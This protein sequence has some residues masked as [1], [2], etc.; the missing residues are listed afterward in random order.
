MT[1]DARKRDGLRRGAAEQ[2]LLDRQPGAQ[3]AGCGLV[4]RHQPAEIDGAAHPRPL[5]GGRE[6][7]DAAQLE[8]VE[9]LRVPRPSMEWMR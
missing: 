1:S 3:V 7:L 9:A 2:H 4:G 8:R 6:V 5:G